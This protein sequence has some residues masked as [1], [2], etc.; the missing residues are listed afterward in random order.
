MATAQRTHDL[1]KCNNLYPTLTSR[2]NAGFE[3]H[4]GLLVK[5]D[6]M[7]ER[8]Y[9]IKKNVQARF[10]SPASPAAGNT[11][12]YAI[13]SMKYLGVEVLPATAEITLLSSDSE[14]TSYPLYTVGN[15]YLYTV[16]GGVPTAN[17]VVTGISPLSLGF[18][19]NNFYKFL[20]SI[21]NL[22][23]I[24]VKVTRTPEEWW[25]SD[26]AVRINN[27]TLEQYYDSNFEFS[28]T[29]TVTN[30]ST[31]VATI[32]T[33]RY[34]FN[35]STV[36][37][38]QNGVLKTISN[39]PATELP[40]Y[41]QYFSFFSTAYSYT[42]ITDINVCPIVYPFSASIAS[43]E[44]AC[45]TLTLSC[46]CN[47]ITFGDNSSYINGLP[48]H[49][50]EFF[51]SRKITLVRPNGTTYV[52]GTSDITPKDKLITPHYNS[53][54]TFQ[55][56]LTSADEDGIYEVTLCTYPDWQADVYYNSY[57]QPIVLINGQ[58][59]KAV[60]SSTNI[61]PSTDTSNT[62]WT[63]YSCDGNCDDTRYCA[64]ERIVVL[65]V[66]IL[67]CY[68]KLVKAAFCGIENNPCKDL[69]DNKD[70]MKA[71]KMRVTLDSLEFAVCGND[72]TSAKK[73]IDILKSICCCG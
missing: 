63:L 55:Y 57:L 49:D 46:D 27:F 10:Y 37:H 24:P 54:N 9:R 67:D 32:T 6:N 15:E 4:N 56:N 22:H 23:D 26:G 11:L 36:Q 58:T 52:W 66:S 62:Y 47:K 7:D 34:V 17:G 60:T 40:Q 61:N 5:F 73:H 43:P 70:F 3:A 68:K 8:S 42:S 21:V 31:G 16:I 25:L 33:F 29:Q 65:C 38:Y 28:M 53:S 59:Y 19:T 18:G 69:C 71:M 39:S 72:W 44:D 41:N 30:I 12:Q 48:G 20:E 50:P 14:F 35:G 2:F 64:K 1:I 13:T 45:S 51:T